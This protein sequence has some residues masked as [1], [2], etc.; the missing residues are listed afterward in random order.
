MYLYNC[1][2]TRQSINQIVKHFSWFY[3]NLAT[4]VIIKQRAQFDSSE[5][6]SKEHTQPRYE[7][8]TIRNQKMAKCAFKVQILYL[9]SCVCTRQSMLSEKYTEIPY[10]YI[11]MNRFYF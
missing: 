6:Y 3:T 11:F 8:N 9:Y 7:I 1:V 10:V 2:C 5:Y 4:R